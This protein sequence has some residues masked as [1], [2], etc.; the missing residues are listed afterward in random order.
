MKKKYLIFILNLMLCSLVCCN[1]VKAIQK[2]EQY[3]RAFLLND[4]NIATS[5]CSSCLLYQGVQGGGLTYNAIVTQKDKSKKI[6]PG[7]QW[8]IYTY[9]AQKSK[10]ERHF[11]YCLDP[12]AAGASKYLVERFLGDGSS[13]M[14]Y[15]IGIMAIMYKG[16]DPDYN[17]SV[18]GLSEYNSQVATSLALRAWTLGLFGYGR[19]NNADD[20]DANYSRI[21]INQGI[22]WASFYHDKVDLFARRLASG[23]CESDNAE[24]TITCLKNRANTI[25]S[26]YN[27]SNEMF[28]DTV[29][30][31]GKAVHEAALK[32]F[33]HAIETVISYE[34]RLAAAEENKEQTETEN[35]NSS[36]DVPKVKVT[37]SMESVNKTQSYIKT[38]MDVSDVSKEEY[39]ISNIKVECEKCSTYGITI[40]AGEYFNGTDWVQFSTSDDLIPMAIK[41][42]KEIQLRFLATTPEEEDVCES[43]PFNV[44]YDITSKKENTGSFETPG[45][46]PTVYPGSDELPNAIPLEEL[47]QYQYAVL[48]AQ[49]GLYD[50]QGRRIYPDNVQR[51][52]FKVRRSDIYSEDSKDNPLPPGIQ[53]GENPGGGIYSSEVV[54]TNNRTFSSETGSIECYKE[55]CSPIEHLPLCTYDRDDA[56]TNYKEEKDNKIKSCILGKEDVAGNSYQLAE[57]NGGVDNEY[58]K[59]FCKED[60]ANIQFTPIIKDVKCGGYFKLSAHVEGTKDCYTGSEDK[61]TGYAI[62]GAQYKEDIK[63]AQELMIEGHDLYLK[64]EAA[65]KLLE[66]TQPKSTDYCADL[67]DYK[68]TVESYVISGSYSSVKA[69]AQDDNGIVPMVANGTVS[70][71]YGTEAS[72]TEEYEEFDRD[73]FL[74]DCAEVSWDP[75]GTACEEAADKAEEDFEPS[76]CSVTCDPKGTTKDEVKQQIE[77]DK[78]DA[79]AKIKEGKDKFDKAINMYNSC[80]TGWKNDFKFAHE[81]YFDYAEEQY[82][83]LLEDSQKKLIP[84]ED[85]QTEE[86]KIEIC[87]GETNEQYECSTDVIELEKPGEVSLDQYGYNESYANAFDKVGFTVCD[88]KTGACTNDGVPVSKAKFIHIGV[89]KK[90]DYITPTVF[91]QIDNTSKIT[92]QSTSPSPNATLVPLENGLPISAKSTGTDW[93]RIS[94]KGLGEFYDTG[95]L[96]RIFDIGGDNQNNSVGYYL[97]QNGITVD[98]DGN[99]TDPIKGWNTE[100]GAGQDGSYYCVF[101][102]ACRP[103]DCPECEPDCPPVTDGPPTCRWKDCPEC[104]VTCV[105]CLFNLNELQLTFKSISTTNFNSA[106]RAIGYNWDV[107]TTLSSLKLISSKASKTIEEITQMN[108]TIYQDNQD[109]SGGSIDKD[110]SS[111]SLGFSIR[112]TPEVTKYIREYNEKIDKQKIG[113]YANDS[114]TCYDYEGFNGIL[115]YSDFID[116]L[117]DKF[118]DQGLITVRNR[119]AEGQRES[120]P[121]SDGYWTFWEDYQ[122]PV[123]SL[124]DPSYP[125]CATS[126][127]GGPAWK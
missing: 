60:Y 110:S 125:N 4:G 90:A 104:D 64:A 89:T 29:S 15:D 72:C 80:T 107:N 92:S 16:Y 33:T 50:R 85:S 84:L 97:Y 98:K 71:S 34:Y 81:L 115:C 95:K 3:T 57:S 47:V 88:D 9:Y 8:R 11:M 118:G 32:L 93:F 61:S 59:V 45:S 119:T 105:N 91:Y 66:T 78:S 12:N 26:F 27:N 21:V 54:D 44:K 111:A 63:A 126:V 101:E 123:C 40:S 103:P 38:V 102:N 19:A 52:V 100:Y 6:V 117:I 114:L 1:D 70:F 87:T 99:V 22:H 31:N 67:S 14:H 24:D 74:S 30:G 73:S 51:F 39:S 75:D 46:D 116:E 86:S 10:T 41:D 106:N 5:A 65:E 79:L 77:K 112:M 94:L 83:N 17:R 56:T 18:N 20:H 13:D 42:G 49:D 43:V 36:S 28:T 120:N 124:D 48:R 113:G 109:G 96:G 122:K 25:Y 121:N 35:N 76:T 82:M 37:N 55:T 23:S 127:I 108:E 62:G 2:G 53:L 68:E 69:G 58:C 7:T